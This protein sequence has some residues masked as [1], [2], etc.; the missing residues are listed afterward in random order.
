MADST[1]REA[2]ACGVTGNYNAFRRMAVGKKAAISGNGVVHC[3]WKGIF[4]GETIVRSENAEAMERE[5]HR[6][7][8]VGFRGTAEVATA[9]Q[10]KQHGVSGTWRFDPFSWNPVHA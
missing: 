7:G 8:A 3:G 10:I 9:V 6:D 4:R 5:P 2:A 1:S